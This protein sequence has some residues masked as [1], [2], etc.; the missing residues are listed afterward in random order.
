ME[1]QK[2]ER[3]IDK[4]K[5]LM[6]L[7]ESPVEAEAAAALAKARRLLTKHGL[8][9][10]DVLPMGDGVVETE[11]LYGAGI[12]PWQLALLFHI[13]LVTHTEA[14]HLTGKHSE[15]VTFIG[16]L[17]DV[18]TAKN[19]FLYLNGRIVRSSR[20]YSS[21]VRDLDGFRMG[22]VDGLGERLQELFRGAD[23]I[24]AGRREEEENPSW[25]ERKYGPIEKEETDFSADPNSYG[26]GKKV[27][28]KIALNWQ[29][30]ANG[31]F[32]GSGA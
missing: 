5:K 26:L 13:S 2:M 22:M 10:T 6:A 25:G 14:L 1:D 4:V 11:V 29:I 19:L 7:S 31:G 3:I 32:S 21:V 8:V 20:G 23:D 27:G 24:R 16:A 15:K 30:G 12:A 18:V 17:K 9:L 28:R